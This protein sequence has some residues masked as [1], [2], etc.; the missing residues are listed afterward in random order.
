MIHRPVR[1]LKGGNWLIARHDSQI[2]KDFDKLNI[3]IPILL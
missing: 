3:S 1:G 2:I